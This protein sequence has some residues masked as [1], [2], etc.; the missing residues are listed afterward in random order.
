MRYVSTLMVWFVVFIPI[1]NIVVARD[2]ESQDFSKVGNWKITTDST[3]MGSKHGCRAVGVFD[4]NSVT[5]LMGSYSP[6][7]GKLALSIVI[8]QRRLPEGFE[9]E[10]N[11]D[12]GR[13]LV[14]SGKILDVGNWAG[15]KRVAFYTRAEF[16]KMEGVMDELLNT[17]TLWIRS[18][19]TVFKP[20]DFNNLG[21]K[22]VMKELNHCLK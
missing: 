2:T 4:G 15:D 5:I 10:A 16:A 12:L 18:N 17:N 22:Q 7:Y 6:Q 9:G 13:G 11:L 21:L 1:P 3:S 14:V 20:V 8:P 19:K